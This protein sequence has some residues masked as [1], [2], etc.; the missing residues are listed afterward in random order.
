LTMPETFTAIWWN[1]GLNSVRSATC[2][3]EGWVRGHLHG[4]SKQGHQLGW[5]WWNNGSQQKRSLDCPGEGWVSG[6]LRRK[7]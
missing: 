2:P 5:G 3:G 7:K 6:M 4:V 1:D